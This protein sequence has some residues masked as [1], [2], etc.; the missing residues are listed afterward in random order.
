MDIPLFDV[1]IDGTD[2]IGVDMISLVKK[3][4][5]L[6]D[7]VYMAEQDDLY[8]KV[9]LEDEKRII[10]GPALIPDLAIIRKDEDGTPYYIKYSKDEIDQIRI[11]FAK[12]KDNYSVNK[13]HKS[14]VPDV[15]IF[16][17]WSSGKED[18]SHSLGFDH[19][20]GTWFVG[21]KV[22]NEEIWQN[23]KTGKYKGFSIEGLF[24]FKK[25]GKIKQEVEKELTL[26]DVLSTLTDEEIK[27]IYLARKKEILKVYRSVPNKDACEFCMEVASKNWQRTQL[28]FEGRPLLHEHCKCKIETRFVLDYAGNY[29]LY[30]PKNK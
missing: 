25:G 24:K 1:Y 17:N 8:K 6:S 19:P 3:G 11:Q 14:P 27:K 30:N 21:M 13:D 10:Y 29:Y 18:K 16:E 12:V 2:E 22:D 23:I 7:F 9:I 5:I 20:E 15:F 4:A 26:Q 28:N